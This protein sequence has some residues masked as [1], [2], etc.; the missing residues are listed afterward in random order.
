MNI[1]VFKTVTLKINVFL[2]S[3]SLLVFGLLIKL[4]FWQLE[5][6]EEKDLR[7]QQMQQYQQQDVLDLKDVLHLM[8][9]QNS[10][11]QS[12]QGQSAATQNPEFLNDLPV[13]LNGSFRQQSFLLDNQ[14]H[15]GQPGYQVLRLFRDS[16]SYRNV[17]VNLGWIP[18][19]ID[20]SV[21]PQVDEIKGKQVFSGKIRIIES[22]IV[23]ADDVLEKD[24]WPQ[25]IQAVDIDKISQLLDTPLLPFVV[26]VDNEEALGHVKEWVPIVMPPEKHR[27]YAFQWFSL[28]VAWVILMLFA[29]YQAAKENKVRETK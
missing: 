21:L 15:Q 26:Y 10:F 23:L 24:S 25:R 14:V 7:L 18:G 11:P 16:V 6:A 13:R 19:S 28:A 2:L 22:S 8:A 17:L 4:G 20:R 29:A 3:L 5:R 27:G 9:S 12:E 1:L